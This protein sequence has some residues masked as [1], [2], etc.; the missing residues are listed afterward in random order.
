MGPLEQAI[1]DLVRAH[2]DGLPGVDPGRLADVLV[3]PTAQ[4]AVGDLEI[5]LSPVVDASASRPA[6]EELARRLRESDA[7]ERVTPIPPRVYLRPSVPFLLDTVVPAVVAAGDAFGR[8][9]QGEGQP[10]LIAF[11]DPNLN[12]PLHLGH[13]RNNFLGMALA[14]LLANQGYDV[15]RNS[16]HSDWGIHICQ[17]LLAY[18]KWGEG[19]TPEST[20]TKGDHFAGTWYVRFHQENEQQRRGQKGAA[21]AEPTPL[22]QEAGDL[23]RRVETGEPEAVALNA[24]L[25]QWVEDGM[26]ETYARIGTRLDLIYRETATWPF[27]RAFL[28]QALADGRAQRRPDDSVCVDLS[29]LDLPEVTFLRGD[30]T[31]LVYASWLGI[32]TQRFPLREWARTIQVSGK[33]W[34]SGEDLY[35]HA[36]GVLGTGWLDHW[37]HAHHG[38]VRLPHGKMRSREGSFVSA[39]PLLDGLTDQLLQEWGKEDPEATTAAHRHTCDRLALGL[40]KYHFLRAR[41]LKDIPYEE[42]ALLDR[43]LPAFA[44]I[45]GTLAW[46]E[47]QAS[48]PDD[49]TAGLP[50]SP[51]VRQ[52]L[53]QLDDLP[54]I[55]RQ[56]LARLETADVARWLDDLCLPV[57]VCRRKGGLP[58]GMAGAVAVG[59]RR[60]LALLNVEPPP[61]LTS[62]P[63][64]FSSEVSTRARRPR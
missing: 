40:L 58:A 55:A 31:P 45:V 56:A 3:A 60:G 53:L 8:G 27:A 61:D 37:E 13:L 10:A 63:P 5:D 52:V 4:P 48:E 32:D 21:V 14:T 22:E 29:H 16:L 34:E 19:V 41:R 28:D 23:L 47:Q 33:E 36:M 46:A 59:I 11:S 17:A 2:G 12:K 9:N 50:D 51:C 18:L 62:L 57:G 15:V 42:Q 39:D 43:A 26:L 49:D 44:T 24:R 1:T 25:T 64:A 20:G 7:V 30:G 35:T 54:R 38:M 6:V